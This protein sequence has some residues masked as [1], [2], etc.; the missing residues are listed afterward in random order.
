MSLPHIIL[1]MLKN[2]YHTGYEI[3]K[4][5][6][7]KTGVY[8]QASH[9]QIYRELNKLGDTGAV[10]FNLVPQLGKPDKKVYSITKKGTKHLTEWT[11][12]V[13]KH[14]VIRD[15]FCAKLMA[16][17]FSPSKGFKLN[18]IEAID[19]AKLKKEQCQLILENDYAVMKNASK[20]ECVMRLAYL[21]NMKF[22][23]FWIEWAEEALIEINKMD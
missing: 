14:N 16:F 21:R 7:K 22:Y 12:E 10:E 13:S 3:S 15:E 11:G 20:Q 17:S 1:T 23:E 19:E 18:F 4:E 6:S 5:F 2:N 9:Q 8:W